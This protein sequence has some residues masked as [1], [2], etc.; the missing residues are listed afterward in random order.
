MADALYRSGEER[1]GGLALPGAPAAVDQEPSLGEKHRKITRR[2]SPKFA[3]S[4]LIFA[5]L[6]SH[7]L[8]NHPR[9]RSP[10][11]FTPL[12]VTYTTDGLILSPSTPIRPTEL[13]SRIKA[14]LSGLVRKVSLGVILLSG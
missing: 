14:D 13:A 6:R 11:T 4:A 10:A 12:E 1:S 7:P 5:L 9:P 2:R 3:R 8:E